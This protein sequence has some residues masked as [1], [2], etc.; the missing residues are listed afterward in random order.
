[1]EKL[2]NKIMIRLGWSKKDY[3]IVNIHKGLKLRKLDVLVKVN[4]IRYF[5]NI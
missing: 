1:M 3:P 5:N 2:G 4:H